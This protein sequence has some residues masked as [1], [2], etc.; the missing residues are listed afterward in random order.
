VPTLVIGSER[1]RLLP[2]DSSR[3]IAAAAP[4]LVGL[5]E[6]SGGHCSILER[7][8]EVNRALRSLVESASAATR[9][10]S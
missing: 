10:S 5:V 2:I 8:A 7:P 9:L 1:D 6:L 4:N 3:K